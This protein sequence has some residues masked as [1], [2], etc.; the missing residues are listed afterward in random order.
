MRRNGR[1]TSELPL[2]LAA[3]QCLSGF[4]YARLAALQ[5]PDGSPNIDKLNAIVTTEQ[6]QLLF[7][8]VVKRSI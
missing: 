6:L 4:P 3:R 8:D 7:H 5:I 1:R 2:S